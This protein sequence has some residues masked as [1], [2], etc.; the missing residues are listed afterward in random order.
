MQWQLVES[1]MLSAVAYDGQR[2]TL[3]VRFL[4][5]EVYR[6]FDVPA[7]TFADFLAA[8]SKGRYFLA[9]IRDRFAYERLAKLHVA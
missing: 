8:D 2:C 3:Y 6:Y 9:S 7:R 1:K 5:G 4:S